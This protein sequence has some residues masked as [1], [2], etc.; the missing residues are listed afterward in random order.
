MN[1]FPPLVRRRSNNEML[2]A[3][4]DRSWGTPGASINEPPSEYR[5]SLNS[6]FR[7]PSR[8]SHFEHLQRRFGHARP[9]GHPPAA[10]KM[11]YYQD[12]HEVEALL[13]RSLSPARGPPNGPIS[14]KAPA[15]PAR[16]DQRAPDQSC[17]LTILRKG[18]QRLNLM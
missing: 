2:A 15:H 8:A 13:P 18:N 9:Q 5:R 14:R 12:P 11:G 17:V 10:V 16:N 7:S 3:N 1:L 6:A 4:Q